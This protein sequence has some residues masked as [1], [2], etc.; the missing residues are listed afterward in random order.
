MSEFGSGALLDEADILNFRLRF[1]I[2]IMRKAFLTNLFLIPFVC[3]VFGS[4]SGESLV[5]GDIASAIDLSLQ[6][7]SMFGFSGAVLLAYK[8]EV[9]LRKGY[10]YADRVREIPIASDTSFAVA[11]ITKP[12]TAAA[13]LK[14]EQLGKLQTGDLISKYIKQVPAD[15]HAITIHHLLTHTSGIPDQYA[16]SGLTGP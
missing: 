9:V 8:G 6:R 2:T 13:I 1:I 11:S 14:L 10:G 7:A 12:F 4:A 16:A 3:S 15:K 5:R